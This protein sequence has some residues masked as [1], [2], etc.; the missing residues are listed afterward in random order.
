MPKTVRI[1]IQSIDKLNKTMGYLLALMLLVMTVV[2]FAQIISRYLLGESL[3]WSEEL[4]RF[5]MVWGVFI[6]SAIATR[7][8]SLIAVEIL[9]QKLP[10]RFAKWVKLLVY[11]IIIIFCYYLFSYGIDMVRQV[12]LQKSPAMQISMAIPYSSVP[13]GTLLIFLN[14]VVVLFES[15][16]KEEAE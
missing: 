4:A 13:I 10:E 15:L 9:P 2:I 12:I 5:I 11:A 1:Y 7:Y 3:S 6:G 16:W 14:T 8:Q